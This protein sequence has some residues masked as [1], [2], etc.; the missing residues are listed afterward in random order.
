MHQISFLGLHRFH[1]PIISTKQHILIFSSQL[2]ALKS[3]C[4][5]QDPLH[6]I[7]HL[8]RRF[9]PGLYRHPL[10]Q[11]LKKR[12]LISRPRIHKIEI[13]I[14]KLNT[15]YSRA[16]EHTLLEVDCHRHNPIA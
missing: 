16:M 2:S 9:T 5:S 14:P 13:S 7:S 10:R 15:P 3:Q 8:N 1:L 12:D 6:M 11:P 4:T